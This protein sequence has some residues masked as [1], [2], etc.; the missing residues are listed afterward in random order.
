MNRTQRS[1]RFWTSGGGLRAAASLLA[2]LG[3]TAWV[4][5]SIDKNYKVLSFFFDGVPDPAKVKEVEAAAAMQGY[6]DPRK[7]PSYSVHKPYAEEKCADCHEGRLRI[8]KYDSTICLKC[9]DQKVS[10]HPVTHGPVVAQACLWCHSPHESAY[11]SLM[12]ARPRDVCTQCHTAA[13]L[14]NPRVPAH[15]DDTK[16]CLACHFGHGSSDRYLM[17]PEGWKQETAGEGSDARKP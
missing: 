12:K 9:H 6:S 17:R 15:T 2:C 7:S 13:M 8:S 10:D 5:C 14:E 3:L 11:P 16:D 1:I 4:G